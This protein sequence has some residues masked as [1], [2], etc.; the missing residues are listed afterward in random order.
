MMHDNL[1]PFLIEIKFVFVFHFLS[2]NATKNPIPY[3]RRLKDSV[4]PWNFFR[5]INYKSLFSVIH[6]IY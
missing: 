4:Y 5:H 1:F 6:W 2:R 3:I